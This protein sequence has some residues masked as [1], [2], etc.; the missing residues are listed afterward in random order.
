MAT[1][2]S[3]MDTINQLSLAEKLV[4][5][6]GVLMLIASFLPWYKVSFSSLGFSTSVS[7]SGWDAP[8]ALWSILAVIIAVVMAGVVISRVAKM[9]LPDLGAITWGQAMLG[10][11]VTVAVLLLIKL[12]NHSGNLSFGFFLGIIAAGL[13]AYGGYL[14]Y[15]EEK[16]S[17]PAV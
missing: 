1:N 4:A 8:G 2:K 10:G 14:L 15:T 11:G 17:G 5:G 3:P 16:S 9:T 12:L 6:G 7:A 13:L